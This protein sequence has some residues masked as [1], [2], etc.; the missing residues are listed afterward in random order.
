MRSLI[1]GKRIQVAIIGVDVWERA[2]SIATAVTGNLSEARPPTL[3]SLRAFGAALPACTDYHVD[4]SPIWRA[5]FVST[6]CE[7]RRTG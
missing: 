6:H 3:E 7:G 5:V 4:S 2:G 1:T